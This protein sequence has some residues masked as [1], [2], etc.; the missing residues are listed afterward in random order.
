M[1]NFRRQPKKRSRARTFDELE[2]AFYGLVLKHNQLSQSHMALERKVGAVEHYV[3][4]A[5][6]TYCFVD[7]RWL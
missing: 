4:A 3:D 6:R 5:T 1:K 7:D 2:T